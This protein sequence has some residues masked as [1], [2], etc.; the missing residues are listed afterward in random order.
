VNQTPGADELRIRALLVAHQVG[1][2]AVPPKPTVPPKPA[3]RP[4]D[5]LDDLLEAQPEPVEEETPQPEPEPEPAVEEPEAAPAEAKPK[6]PRTKPGRKAK[7]K[8]RRPKPGGAQAAWDT[9]PPSPRQSLTDAWDRVPYRL[10]WLGYHA[11]AAYLG[12]S[13]GLVGY[14]TYVT[15]W[16]DRTGLVGP[17]AVFWY[18]AAAGTV[19]VYRRTRHWW[20]PVAWLAAVPVTSTVVGVLLYAP[21]P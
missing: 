19:L 8:S 15:A 3:A 17:Q 16:I 13:T 14:A 1:P 4:R 11:S 2:D 12:W 9:R 10:K 20:K 7:R 18:G 21:H 6:K 5:W